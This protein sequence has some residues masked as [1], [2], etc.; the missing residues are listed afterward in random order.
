MQKIRHREE[1]K[2]KAVARGESIEEWDDKIVL[3]GRKIKTA[4]ATSAEVQE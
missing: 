1:L 2:K 3:V 4:A